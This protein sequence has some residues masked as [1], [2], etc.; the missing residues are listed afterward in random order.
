MAISARAVIWALAPAARAIAIQAPISSHPSGAL[1]PRQLCVAA[2]AASTW[3]GRLRRSAR[4]G[5][6]DLAGFGRSFSMVPVVYECRRNLAHGCRARGRRLCARH[7]DGT[8]CPTP[9]RLS[10][11]M[12]LRPH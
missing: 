8:M 11:S 4:H 12:M 5:R 3:A 7:E 10:I 2:S 1:L 6:A 9:I